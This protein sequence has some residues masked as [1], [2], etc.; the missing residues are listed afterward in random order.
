MSHWSQRVPEKLV[1]RLLGRSIKE[2]APPRV[3]IKEGHILSVRE[4]GYFHVFFH[5]RRNVFASLSLRKLIIQNCSD[6]KLND[7]LLENIGK[8]W[9]GVIIENV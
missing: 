5:G 3:T 1:R 4:W 8:M 2:G 9:R 6:F 7:R